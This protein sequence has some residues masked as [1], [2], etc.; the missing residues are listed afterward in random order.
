M[1][2]F[3]ADIATEVDALVG[4]GAADGVDFEAIETAVR[5]RALGFAARLVEGRLND[6][7]NHRYIPRQAA[8]VGRCQGNLWAWY[9]HGR[10][11]GEA[12][13]RRTR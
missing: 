2:P 7:P 11:L 4:P 3:A 13:S 8:L 10:A 1:D 5:R 12:P 6:H 9:R